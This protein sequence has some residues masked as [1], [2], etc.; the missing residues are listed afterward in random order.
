MRS[1][2]NGA[3]RTSF[4]DSTVAEQM[5]VNQFEVSVFCFLE[6]FIFNLDKNRK[7]ESWLALKTRARKMLLVD[8]WGKTV[9]KL[10]KIKLKSWTNLEILAKFCKMAFFFVSDKNCKRLCLHVVHDRQGV[11]TDAG[12]GILKYR[13]PVILWKTLSKLAPPARCEYCCEKRD[14]SGSETFSISDWL[15]CKNKISWIFQR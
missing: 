15:Y 11:D 1:V 5:R 2:S 4:P 14:T 6:S 12:S 8:L 13:Y 3:S 7:K 10:I 9:S